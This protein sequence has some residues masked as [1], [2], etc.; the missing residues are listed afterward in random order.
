MQCSCKL[1]RNSIS[2]FEHTLFKALP[3]R[4][5]ASGRAVIDSS[6]S[7]SPT[8]RAGVRCSCSQHVSAP[9]GFSRSLLCPSPNCPASGPHTCPILAG[10]LASPDSSLL[11]LPSFALPFLHFHRTKAS[12]DTSFCDSDPFCHHSLPFHLTQVQTLEQGGMLEINQ[13]NSLSL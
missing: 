10:C 13:P 9:F 8:T 4:A 2:V 6:P 11:F 12:P 7:G 3:P 1:W 5:S